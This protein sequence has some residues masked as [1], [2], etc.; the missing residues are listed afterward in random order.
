[1]KENSSLLV[2]NKKDCQ[3]HL[4]IP[5]ETH[6]YYVVNDILRHDSDD[7]YKDNPEEADTKI[8][9]HAKIVNNV[10]RPGAIVVRGS[11]TDIAVILLYHCNKFKSPIWRDVGLSSKKNRR[12]I[13]ITNISRILGPLL[14]AALPGFHAFKGCDYT[15]EFVRKGKINPFAK[16]VNNKEVQ[17][18][19][20][21]LA[22]DKVLSP[23]TQTTLQTLT[24]IIYGAK[25]RTKLTLNEFRYKMFEK[26]Y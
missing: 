12:Y 13:S 8:L 20:Y 1:M 18:A 15:S 22:T 9:L 10:R 5:G 3:L 25:E 6:H 24:T 16:L 26:G 11:D 4:D 7:D 21:L 19:F 14:C 17:K 23:N 2:L